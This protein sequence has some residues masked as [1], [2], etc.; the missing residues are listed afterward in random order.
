MVCGH[1]DIIVHRPQSSEEHL[2]ARP[3]RDSLFRR[4][5]ATLRLWRERARQR[6][7]LGRLDDR[8]LADIGVTRAEAERECA[9]PFWRTGAPRAQGRASRLPSAI[10]TALLYLGG[11]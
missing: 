9:K 11:R 3:R 8:L 10:A 5:R 6:H 2:P 1:H 4:C 7:A